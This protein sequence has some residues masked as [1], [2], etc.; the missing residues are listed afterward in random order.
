LQGEIMALIHFNMAT[1]FK[2]GDPGC[3]GSN[4]IGETGSSNPASFSPT[5]LNTTQW[6]DSMLALGA[7]EAV[8]TAKHGCGFYLW[9][10]NVT[11]PNGTLYPYHVDIAKYG[12]CRQ[13]GS[14]LIFCYI[15]WQYNCI[16][17]RMY[18]V[19]LLILLPLRELVMAFTTA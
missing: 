1:F 7:T 3:D 11:L 18:F 17:Y 4:W 14:P 16:T 2:N 8:L 5:Q 9:P 10:T 19:S 6:V 13:G 15:S 12:V